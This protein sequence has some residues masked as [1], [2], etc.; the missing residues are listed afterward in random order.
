MPKNAG[1]RFGDENPRFGP[2]PK[3]DAAPEGTRSGDDNV[4]SFEWSS[5]RWREE[6]ESSQGAIE[7]D[8]REHDSAAPSGDAHGAINRKGNR[9]KRGGNKGQ[10]SRK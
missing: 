6:T 2:A 4:G 3:P 7:K 1:R 5:P 8:R 10:K 9:D